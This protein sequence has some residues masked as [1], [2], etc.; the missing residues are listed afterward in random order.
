MDTIVRGSIAGF[1]ATIVYGVITWILFMLGVLPST[2]THYAA[3]F[4]TPPGT[5]ISSLTLFLGAVG[6]LMAG[7]LA[8]V[9]LAFILK[10]TGY[11]YSLF[12]GIGLGFVLWPVHTS[13][14]PT[15]IGPR[16]YET[17]SPIMVLF[18]LFSSILW[19]IVTVV[20]LKFEIGNKA[21]D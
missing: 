7:S 20:V 14:F 16:L 13:F 12:K 2:F 11:D 1:I 10:W 19:G 15:L 6:N 5:V 3:V 4:L 8:G 21:H 9:L 17:L 18:T